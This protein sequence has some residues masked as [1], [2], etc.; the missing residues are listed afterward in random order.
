MRARIYHICLPARWQEQSIQPV[1][2]DPSL[3]HEGFI[4][5]STKE[6][7]DATLARYFKGIPELTILE[8]SPAEVAGTL[9]FEPAPHSQE[10]FPHVY[11]PIPRSAILRTHRFDWS[12]PAR[13]IIDATDSSA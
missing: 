3:E 10:R 8:I 7:L 5:C 9:R 11:G 12:L 2:I 13:Q 6:Q 4:H 1:F